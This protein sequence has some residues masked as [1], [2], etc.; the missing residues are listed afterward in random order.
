MR[1]LWTFPLLLLVSAC[2]TAISD[3]AVCDGLAPLVDRH[4]DALLKD[5]GDQSVTTG[6]RLVAGFD[7][8]CE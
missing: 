4:A 7:A 1:I 6:A 5:G 3:S 2:A 8:A